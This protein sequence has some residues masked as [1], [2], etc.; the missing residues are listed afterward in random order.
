MSCTSS[1]R[2]GGSMFT[3][4]LPPISGAAYDGCGRLD[5]GPSMA[6]IFERIKEKLNFRASGST[7]DFIG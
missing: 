5:F 7:I 1:C 2:I 4:A 6:Q 3:I